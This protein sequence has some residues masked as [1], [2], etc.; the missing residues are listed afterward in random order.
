[1]KDLKSKRPGRGLA[2]LASLTMIA[3]MSAVPALGGGA[4]RSA[5]TGM[6][7]PTRKR[8]WART[9]P[10][11]SAVKVARAEGVFSYDQEAVTPNETITHDVPEGCAQ[12]RVRR[13]VLR[14]LRRTRSTGKLTVSGDGE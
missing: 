4:G 6:Q 11:P 13:M 8:R 2:A 7:P 1:M 9:P 14:L 3:S 10:W 12:C 5:L